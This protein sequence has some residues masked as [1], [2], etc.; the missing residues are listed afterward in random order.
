MVVESTEQK[1][2]H[3]EVMFNLL[4]YFE[5][6]PKFDFWFV[7]YPGRRVKVSRDGVG[8]I[9]FGKCKLGKPS[10]PSTPPTPSP[11]WPATTELFPTP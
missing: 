11:G 8:G 4:G 10:G 6:Y 7:Q 1:M 9:V 5:Y 3:E 2:S